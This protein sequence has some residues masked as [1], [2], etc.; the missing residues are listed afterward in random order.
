MVVAVEAVEG[1]DVPGKVVAREESVVVCEAVS[2]A[3][4]LSSTT[5]AVVVAFTTSWTLWPLYD[6]A[7]ALSSNVVLD[8]EVL[9]MERT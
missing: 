1:V 8:T 6:T 9:G 5:R 3:G 7:L 2:G 4:Y